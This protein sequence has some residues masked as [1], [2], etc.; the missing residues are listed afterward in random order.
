MK[1]FAGQMGALALAV[2]LSTPGGAQERALSLDDQSF[3]LQR[4]ERQGAQDLERQS[5]RPMSHSRVCS[6]T[7][8]VGNASCHAH[9][10]HDETGRPFATTGPAGFVPTDLRAAYSVTGNGQSSTII[11]IVDA[12]GYPNAE[13][14]LATNRAH[15]AGGGQQRQSRKSMPA[16]P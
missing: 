9:L 6:S 5:H 15:P 8:E 3:I 12:D 14:D 7:A 4:M 2:M 1:I 16:S 11:A 13:S 10:V